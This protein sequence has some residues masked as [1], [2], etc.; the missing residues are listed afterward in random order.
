MRSLFITAKFLA[1]GEAPVS[2]IYKRMALFLDAV[3][4]ISDHL[5]LVT[6]APSDVPLDQNSVDSYRAMYADLVKCPFTLRIV[7]R[8]P[9][10]TERTIRDYLTR[11]W[12]LYSPGFHNYYLTAGPR[13]VDAVRDALA[14][15]PDLVFVHRLAA[16]AALLRGRMRH[17][18]L[19]FDLDDVEH[20]AHVRHILAPPRWRT[21]YLGLL[22]TPP[23]F[24]AEQMAIAQARRT[25]VCSLTDRSYLQRLFRSRTIE[26]VPNSVRIPPPSQVTSLLTL[27][28]LGTYAFAP[29]QAAA[30]WLIGTIWPLVRAA[31]PNATLL[32]AGEFS[33]SLRSH[34]AQPDGVEFRGFV[35]DLDALYAETRVVVCPILSGS[36]TRFKIIE[37]F[38]YGRPVVSTPIGAEG[39]DVEDGR[40][41]L[42]CETAERFAAGCIRLLRDSALAEQLGKQARQVA[43]QRYDCRSVVNGI[44]KSIREALA[45]APLEQGASEP[46]RA[47]LSSR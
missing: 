24:L 45:E 35:A 46:P 26:A 18:A 21:K 9:R 5:E 15:A 47:V 29:N 2:G 1:D 14:R 32:I 6:F 17:P 12:D 28:F 43:E 37:A 7:P 19:F 10:N 31:V 23:V 8:L 42:L 30:D 36:G 33:E 22:H 39:L 25:Y 13:Q 11:P 38:A 41:I 16:M 20:R 40:N 34:A 4:T 44:V 3:S 27:L